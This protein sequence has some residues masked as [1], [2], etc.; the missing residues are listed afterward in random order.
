MPSTRDRASTRSR[1]SIRQARDDL[2][3]EARNLIVRARLSDTENTEAGLFTIQHGIERQLRVQRRERR[4]RRDRR[5]GV[6]VRVT[7]VNE[8]AET[9]SNEQSPREENTTMTDSANVEPQMEDMPGLIEE[10]PSEETMDTDVS[11]GSYE[12]LGLL[13]NVG[14]GAWQD[15]DWEQA[16]RVL[17]LDPSTPRWPSS[18]N[19]GTIYVPTRADSVDDPLDLLRHIRSAAPQPEESVE[20]TSME[21]SSTG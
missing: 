7:E 12:V 13:E 20:R 4:D 9:T 17:G 6:R 10:E 21:V 11:E 15:E 2:L 3:T 1:S 8:S 5:Q 18:D 19:E 16:A 14:N